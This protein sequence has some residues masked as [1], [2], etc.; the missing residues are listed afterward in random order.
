MLGDIHFQLKTS[1]RDAI[2]D[3]LDGDVNANLVSM[4]E[5]DPEMV[6]RNFVIQADDSGRVSRVIE[7]P[8]YVDSQL[9][10]CGLYVFDQHIFDAIRRTPRTA[11]RDEYEITDSIQILIDDGYHVRHTPIVERDLNLTKPEDL[12]MIN[13]MELRATDLK[14]LVDESVVAHEG[15]IIANSVIGAGVVIRHPI[16]ITNSVIMAGVNVDSQA[17]L[18]GVVMS[19]EHCGPVSALPPEPARVTRL[20][21]ACSSRAARD[22]SAPTPCA[23]A[24]ARA[25]GHGPRQSLSRATRGGPVGRDA[26][27]RAMCAIATRVAEALHG[28]DAIIHLAAQV[29]IRGSF[30][31]FYEDLDTNLMGTA[32]LLRLLDPG[33][34]RWF[35][36]ASS[37]A[38]YADLTEAGTHLRRGEDRADFA[39]RCRQA[40]GRAGLPADAGGAQAF[41]SRSCASSTR[42]DLARP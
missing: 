40:R 10:G 6:K 20:S 18:D 2:G 37:M 31:R 7:K 22:S 36:L 17:D 21:R 3:V 9:K 32:N 15:A 23:P 25:A 4:Y 41:R 19:G 13:L 34:I 24:G 38:V 42:S 11:L 35:T 28:V 26:R 12:L 1:L 29:T 30:E 8:R 14:S 16:R 39:V 27:R 33:R 5:P